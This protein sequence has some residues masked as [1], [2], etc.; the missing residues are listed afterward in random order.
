MSANGP[1]TCSSKA[2][3]ACQLQ[4]SATLGEGNL[5]RKVSFGTFIIDTLSLNKTPTSLRKFSLILSS[6]T[7]KSGTKFVGCPNLA[8]C[9]LCI[10]ALAVVLN[11]LVIFFLPWGS[12]ANEFN[13]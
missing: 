10:V 7:F 12:C 1:F 6:A 2:A 9:A 11:A 5:V 3:A 4:L 13:F 8:C